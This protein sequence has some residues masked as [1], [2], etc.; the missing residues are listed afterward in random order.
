[1]TDP[2]NGPRPAEKA[3]VLV[4]VCL[5]AM[6]MPLTFTGAAVALPAIGRALGGNP[7]ALNWVTN[8]FMLAFGSSLMAAGALADTHGRKRVFLAGTAVFAAASLGLTFAPGILAFDL[9]RAAQGLAAAAALS[10]GMAALAQTFDGPARIR[11]FSFI[12][13]SFGV[14]LAFG[15]IAAGLMIDAF[16]WRSIFLLVVL[17]ALAAFAIGARCL[18][19]SRDPAASGLD[20]PGAA[21]FTLALTLFTTGVLQAPERG[22]GDALVI[23]ALAGAA[24]LLAAFVAVERRVARPMLDLS[25][26]RYPRFVG[27]QLLAAA[28][29]Y[30]FVVLLV[31]LPLRFIGVEGMGEV[32]AGQLMIALSAPLLVLPLI[33]GLLT[34]WVSPALI[35]GAGLG[36]AA[37]GLYWLAHVP[38]STAAALVPPMLT[39]GAG[40]G[41]PW[42][43]MDGLAVSVV[44]KERAGMAT[45]IFNTIRVA[46]EGV[47]LAVV[48][49]VLS[50]LTAARLPAGPATAEAAQRLVTG[51]LAGAA[52]VL[53]GLGRDALTASY[54]AAF[55]ALLLILTAITALTALVVLFALGYGR[56]APAEPGGIGDVS[57][58]TGMGAR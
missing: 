12:G 56:A 33:A 27:V 11:A 5:A 51:D 54:D 29:A 21:S 17:L 42:G 3:L 52:A 46:G 8:A 32:A 57:R 22:W 43:L 55:V 44:P 26:F 47:A 28:P 13:T 10:G 45:G 1:M 58:T 36:L 7:V 50:G 39:I 35:A 31:L 34:R 15:P 25:L 53:P 24:L 4:A 16:G 49:A 19:E 2:T 9:L 20:W 30:A 40:I 37:A 6:A 14:G 23:G 38:A 18:G 41:L 48:G